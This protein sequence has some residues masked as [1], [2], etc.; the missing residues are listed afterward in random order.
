[1]KSKPKSS[2]AGVSAANPKAG[3][4]SRSTEPASRPAATLGKAV[5]AM[6]QIGLPASALLKLQGD[7]VAESTAMWN[8]L[9]SLP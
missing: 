7:Y 4:A 5:E 3:S 2:G 8:Q 9:L 1:M 6:A